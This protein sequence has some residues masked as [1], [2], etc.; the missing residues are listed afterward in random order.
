MRLKKGDLVTII[1]G[2][3]RGK[4]GKVLEVSRSSQRI[5]VE[6]LNL[7]TRNV[8]A[9]RQGQKGQRIEFAAPMH[10][11]NVMIMCPKCSKPTRLGRRRTGDQA[12]RFCRRC[13]AA[14]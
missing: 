2:K 11:S 3:D 5:V 13:Q 8:R 14:L 12:V 1:T 9:R 6:G 10:A 7:R 4:K